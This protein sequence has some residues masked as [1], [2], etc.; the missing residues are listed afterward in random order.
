MN[1][2]VTGPYE[3]GPSLTPTDTA[4]STDSQAATARTPEPSGPQ[5]GTFRIIREHA[6]GGLGQVSLALDQRL[7]RHVAL[8]EIRPDRQALPE[9]RRRFVTEAEITGMLEHPGVVPVYAFEED[10][11][12]RP[13][14]AMRFVQGR[15]LGEAIREFHRGGGR[16]PSFS[17]RAFRELLQRFVNVCQAVGYAHSKGVIHR[18]LK[19]ANVMVGDYGET[20]VVDW[21]LAKRT[22]IADPAPGGETPAGAA[23]ATRVGDAVGTPGYMAPEQARGEGDR[24]GAA[25]D[26]FGL[27]AILYEILTVHP[28]YRGGT[29]AE[30]L[31][32]A[33]DAGPPPPR[34]LQPAVPKPL[35][36]VCRKAL[37]ARPAD[38]YATAQ[39]LA[40]DLSRWLAD[41]PVSA[42]AEPVAIRAGRWVR[43][44]R[45]LVTGVV[46]LLLAAAP[47]ATLLAVNREQARRQAEADLREIGKQKDLAQ[48]NERTARE[49]EAETAAV[50][51]FVEDRVLAAA[52][53]KDQDGGL[54]YDVGLADALKASLP[55]LEASFKDQ[56]LVEARLRNTLGIS[57]FHLGEARIA[58][59]QFEASRALYNR[60]HGPDH[61][62][63]LQSTH[64]L[65]NSYE[66]LGRYAEA[67]KRHEETL[68]RR[69]AKL[70]PEDPATLQSLV[71]LASTYDE[72]GRHGDALKL[73]EEVL[74]QWQSKVGPDHPDT[75]GSMNNLA[76]SYEALGR[77]HDALRL[78]E[79]V[80]MLR[81]A[82]LGPDHPETLRS[83]GNLANSY[84]ALG[85]HDEAFRLN[86]ETLA[87]RKAKLGPYHPETLSAM[88]SLAYSLY[89]LGR[90]AEALKL[91]E[92]VLALRKVKL[93]PDHPDTL[94]GMNSLA[95]TYFEL[96]RTQEALKLNEETFALSKAKLGPEHPATLRSM[97]NLANS[98]G[99]LGRQTDALKLRERLL[100]LFR[101][102]L[103]PDH[104]DT[105]K[106]MNNLAASYEHF[107]RAGE[108]LKLYQEALARLKANLGP[109]HPFTLLEMGNLANSLAALGRSAEA[110]PL[111]DECLRR[112]AGRPVHPQLI[113]LVLDLRLRHFEKAGDA[114]GC[115]ATAERWEGTKRT[116]AES[117]YTAACMRAVTAAVARRASGA[118]GAEA[119]RTARA[120]ADRAMAWLKRAVAAG[121][122]Q[123]ERIKKDR[124]LDALRDREDF[125][126]L[127]ADL[128]KH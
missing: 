87:L 101:A 100:E 109:D 38:R 126:K 71:N 70:G 53:P 54:G 64:N 120:D 62:A 83:M 15:T 17:S 121:F 40:D 27:G 65:A 86:T 43:R 60:H 45:Q 68:A 16:P 37:A 21:G 33:R 6:R 5:R 104:A 31:A 72:M 2:P 28:P 8:K 41:E 81:K 112:S 14:Y 59:A 95:A 52:R 49:R 11:A 67:V 1:E 97:G 7:K 85:K 32:R 102:R 118:P 90:N 44:H 94:A 84:H 76:L 74:L 19:P 24:V 50:L 80:L 36:A 103:G 69:Q 128:G 18:D 106:T 73:R 98:Y 55:F 9:L 61:P 39:R 88:S 56:P 75:L 116:D 99:A 122:K 23:G 91:D 30:V 46:A 57:F 51:G 113:P 96:G 34:Q 124:D 10:E 3:P 77:I 92:E 117:L 79:Q 47:L 22:G 78:R 105:L 25:A 125:K 42:Y 13:Y 63:T 35:D 89:E 119:T 114:A 12:G 29:V 26:V 127:L 123:G 58:A 115:R 66:A 93:G 108:A 82:S 110:L 20:L 48:A 4:L 111:I 107:G